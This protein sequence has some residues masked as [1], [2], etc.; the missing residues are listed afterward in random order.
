[1]PRGHVA[2]Q[3][4]GRWRVLSA[5]NAKAAWLYGPCFGLDLLAYVTGHTLRGSSGPSPEREASRDLAK[6]RTL[7]G[8]SLEFIRGTQHVLLGAPDPFVLGSGVPWRSGPIDTPRDVLSFL[9]TWGP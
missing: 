5:I 4:G 8:G 6:S 1:M 9:A 2:R 3:Y 7:L